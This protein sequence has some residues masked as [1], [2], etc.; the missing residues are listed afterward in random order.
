MSN[1]TPVFYVNK[2]YVEQHPDCPNSVARVAWICEMTRGTVKVY[3]A[4]VTYL[5]PPS[6]QGFIPIDQLTAQ[7]VVDW[8]TQTQGGQ[9]WV[10]SYV[11]LH[12]DAMQ[13]AERNAQMQNWPT[14]LIN[15]PPVPVPTPPPTL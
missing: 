1:I 3:G 10:D 12:E 4:G 14:P 6:P 9:A 15:Q 11:A 13:M 8:V 2:V 5:T 7:Q